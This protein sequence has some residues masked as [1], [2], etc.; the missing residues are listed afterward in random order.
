[1]GVW[2]QHYME[3]MIHAVGVVAHSRGMCEPRRRRLL[4]ARAVVPDG[5]S[6]PTNEMRPDVEPIITSRP[7]A[8]PGV[9]AQ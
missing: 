6:V 7:T 3:T 8:R 2:A 1:M 4:Q 9:P 5:R